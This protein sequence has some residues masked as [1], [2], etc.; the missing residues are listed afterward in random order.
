MAQTESKHVR[1]RRPLCHR[2]L[3]LH[4]GAFTRCSKRLTRLCRN[5][6]DGGSEREQGE[7]AFYSKECACACRVL[8]PSRRVDVT[9]TRGAVMVARDGG[10]G[11]SLL[12]KAQKK[13]LEEEKVL[14][15]RV[16]GDER[17]GER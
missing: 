13:F 15:Q 6:K 9:S 1:L 16:N 7:C 3:I 8:E 12:T 5:V 10:G 2:V 14:R 11:E 4:T 17:D